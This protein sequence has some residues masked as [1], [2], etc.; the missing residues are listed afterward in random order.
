MEDVDF[1]GQENVNNP[2]FDSENH[3][4]GNQDKIC[5]NNVD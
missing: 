1:C 5:K 3:K 4:I 2:G